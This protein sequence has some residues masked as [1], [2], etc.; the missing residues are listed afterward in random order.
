VNKSG[1]RFDPE[2]AK[3]FNHQYIVNT[4]DEILAQEF[5][6]ILGDKGISADMSVVT[7]VVALVKERINFVSELW[8]Q[9][10]FFFEAPV[11]YDAKV[12]KKRWKGDV[13]PFMA[14]LAAVLN[15]VNTWK[16]DEIK[17][18]ISAKIEEK[19]LGFGLVMNAFRLALVGGGF[20]PDLMTIAEVIGKDETISRVNNAVQAL[21]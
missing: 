4:S 9:T 19:G 1:A 6:D 17:S 13:P 3:W 14:D 20:G 2:K 18:F 12:V 15:G 21:A 7:Q 5:M 16:A 8:D 11:E 10:S